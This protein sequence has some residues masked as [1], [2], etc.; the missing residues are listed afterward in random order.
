MPD[1]ASAGLQVEADVLVIGGGLAAT[2]AAVG[3]A[4]A[5]AQVVL[6]DKGWCGASGVTATAGPGHWWVAPAERAA[7]IDKQ[8]ERARGLG[9]PDWMARVLD[10]T[11]RSL[12]RL[13]AYYDF[14]RDEAGE[15][16]YRALRGPEYLRGMRR[17]ALDLGVRILDHCPALEL[18]QHRDGSIAGAAGLRRQQG[19][20][21]TARAGAVVLATGGC[22]FGS[23]LLGADVDTGDGLLMGA[24]AGVELSGM[25]FTSY[26]TVAPAGSNMTRSVSYA[27]ASYRDAAGTPLDIPA[28]DATRPLA[29]AMLQGPVFCRLDRMPEAFRERLHLIQ[30][31]VLMALNRSGIDPFEDWFE[32]TLRG[33]GTIRGV[34]GLKV[35]DRDC[36]TRTPGL[37]VAGDTA[38]REPVAGAVSGGGA[39]NS[40]WAVSS[41]QWAGAG[42]ALLARR[43][44][45]RSGEAARP[46]GQ[47]GLRPTSSSGGI[48]ARE[49]IRAVGAELLAYDRNIFRRGDRLAQSLSRLEGLWSDVAA[50]LG[51]EGRARLK[52]REAAAITAAGR[53]SYAAALARA[54]SRGLHQRDDA[55]S[56]AQAFGGRI[57]VG[58]LDHPWTRLETP[59]LAVRET[60]A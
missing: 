34:G 21:W 52:A 8:L 45:R 54:E 38:S 20:S 6:A 33:E 47:A 60:A 13:A 40:A 46:L 24:E 51:G 27:F 11:W 32:V 26:Y 48:D 29:R 59:P 42:A 50:R 30:P 41:G 7:A 49:T 35:D 4:E 19:E 2:W 12:P 31:S 28:G 53:W 44:G 55:P 36:Q 56:E 5:G 23:R 14:P 10:L 43:H 3:A 37:F 15:P 17:M 16:R 9:D 18:L 25:E 22:A 57:S 39:V 1:Q 58:G